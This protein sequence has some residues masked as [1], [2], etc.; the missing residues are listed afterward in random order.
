[1]R[2]FIQNVNIGSGVISN[3]LSKVHPG[4]DWPL[5]QPG[6]NEIKIITD[7]GTQD[8]ELTYFERFGGL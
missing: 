8:W 5:L 1:M 7:Q 2:K 3:L 4:S 6:V